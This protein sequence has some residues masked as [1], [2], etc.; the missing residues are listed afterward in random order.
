MQRSFNLKTIF[1]TVE[2]EKAVIENLENKPKDEFAQEKLMQLWEEF[3]NQLLKANKIPAYNA[4]HTG[5]LELK[6]NFKIQFEFSSAS[7][8]NEFDLEKDNLMW[9]LREKLNNYAIDFQVQVIQDDTV[10]YIKTKADVFKEM[11]E[12]NPILLKMKEELG[13]DYN[14]N[15]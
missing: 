8:A 11:A 7:L 5:K 1:N 4:L 12:K 15:E 6:D 10:K 3:L 9:F 14:S 13:L 2:E